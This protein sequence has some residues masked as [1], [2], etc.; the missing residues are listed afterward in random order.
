MDPF[1]HHLRDGTVP[2]CDESEASLA[3]PTCRSPSPTLLERLRADQRS[4][5]LETW[6][7][8]P[9]HVH[10]IA[11]D[12]HGP[13]LSSAVITQLVEVLAEF[14]DVFSKSPTDFGSCSLMPFEITVP[15]NSS[16]VASRPYRINIPTAENVDAVLD[17]FLAGRGSHLTLHIALGDT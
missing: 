9:P 1:V 11:F 2:P 17:K 12:L 4:S 3:Q 15:P 14:S 5:F 7:R 10:E 13:G 16:S 8:L 6:N